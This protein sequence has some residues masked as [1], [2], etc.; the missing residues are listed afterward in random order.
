MSWIYWP[1]HDDIYSDEISG[2]GVG[3]LQGNEPIKIT[4][5]TTTDYHDKAEIKA[6]ARVHHLNGGCTNE[7]AY[8]WD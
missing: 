7:C 3:F 2:Y 5:Y 1:L 8:G 6:I 4:E